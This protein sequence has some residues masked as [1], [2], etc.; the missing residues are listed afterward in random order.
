MRN[1]RTKRPKR[2]LKAF[3]RFL[4]GKSNPL[5]TD[6]FDRG[7]SSRAVLKL[8]IRPGRPGRGKIN[9][10]WFFIRRQMNHIFPFLHCFLK[11]EKVLQLYSYLVL[12]FKHFRMVYILNHFYQF[13]LLFILIYYK[14]LY[15]LLYSFFYLLF[16][17]KCF[18]S[19]L[20][21]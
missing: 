12:L 4:K 5:E 10:Y 1:K 3:L 11:L 15:I 2:F 9:K 16:Q 13:L 18:Q 20:N 6:R 19:F 14:L 7:R 8:K 21:Y 17:L